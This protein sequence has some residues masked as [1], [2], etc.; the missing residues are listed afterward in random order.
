MDQNRM[1]ERERMQKQIAALKEIAVYLYAELEFMKDRCED[2][3]VD[4]C[5]DVWAGYA[6]MARDQLRREHPEAF[7]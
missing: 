7:Q 4:E 2:R 1:E 6:D 3:L 5:G